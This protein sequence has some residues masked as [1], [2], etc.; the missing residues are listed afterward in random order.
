MSPGDDAPRDPRLLEALRHAPDA[1]A[2]PPPAL[3][4]AILRAAHEAVA[5]PG[6]AARALAVWRWLARPP[7]A[8]GFAS[9][10][11]ATLVGL[12]WWGRPI[13]EGLRGPEPVATAPA[14]APD[15]APAETS[16][17]AKAP[18]P[19]PDAAEAPAVSEATRIRSPSAAPPVRPAPDRRAAAAPAADAPQRRTEEA[20]TPAAPVAAPAAP[21]VAEA[22][23]ARPE[24]HA[25]TGL[26][27]RGMSAGS[28]SAR[29]AP[30]FDALRA[31]LRAEPLRYRW[32]RGTGPEQPID[33]TLTAWLARADAARAGPWQPAAGAPEAAPLAVLRVTAADGAATVITLE[34]EALRLDAGDRR[35]RAAL[36]PGQA[37]ALRDALP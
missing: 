15:P 33:D 8:A 16:P 28:A 27:D 11:L 37:G 23:R 21:A 35:E 17:Q 24:R 19:S 13:D 12:M 25:E 7:V 26:A 22:M 30:A 9:V 3:S 31:A 4:R 1:D 32:Q 10:M 14:A 36:A 34:R 18:P 6:W 20:A 2:A 5:P 29:A